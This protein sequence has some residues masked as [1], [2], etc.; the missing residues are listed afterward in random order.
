[1]GKTK[2]DGRSFPI[3]GD[4]VRL[5]TGTV[6]AGL[7]TIGNKSIIAPNLVIVQ[8]VAEETLMGGILAYPIKIKGKSAPKF[9]G[10]NN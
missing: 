8:D 10:Q 5:L 2:K 7:I 3:I 1:M 4:N 6:I 9:D